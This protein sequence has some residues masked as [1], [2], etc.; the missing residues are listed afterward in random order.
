MS[1]LQ[2]FPPSGGFQYV[3][4]PD[5]YVTAVYRLLADLSGRTGDGVG[6][7]APA[8]PSDGDWMDDELRG[9]A[10]SSLQIASTTRAVLDALSVTPGAPM[11][12]LEL[13]E[14]TGLG[15]KIKNMPTQFTRTLNARYQG[16]R[17]PL[18]QGWGT[19][20]EEPRDDQMYY[21]ITLERAAQWLRIRK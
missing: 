3:P 12:T 20:L 5:E 15:S 16:K 2:H 1:D 6:G 19:T 21:W 11:S 8:E 18:E 7:G 17:S 10:Y 14:K 13:A 9:F 4:V